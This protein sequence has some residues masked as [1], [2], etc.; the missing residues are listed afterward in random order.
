MVR[1]I[2]CAI[3]YYRLLLI[4]FA[5]QKRHSKKIQFNPMFSSFVRVI[6]QIYKLA[7]NEE[8]LSNRFLWLF[9]NYLFSLL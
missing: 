3:E 8:Y 7:S 6:T 5:R 4:Q 1:Q 2:K 9:R